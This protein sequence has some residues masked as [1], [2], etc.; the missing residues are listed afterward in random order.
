MGEAARAGW[1]GETGMFN[2]RIMDCHWTALVYDNDCSLLGKDDATL[3]IVAG[4]AGLVVAIIAICI[5]I[6]C[7]KTGK[8]SSTRNGI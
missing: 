3:L 7:W 1:G 4:C 8:C 5:M 6:W 2:T